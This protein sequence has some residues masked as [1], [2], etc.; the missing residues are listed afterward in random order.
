MATGGPGAEL[1][2]ARRSVATNR[3]RFVLVCRMSWHVR[4]GQ[5][6]PIQGIQGQGGAPP[7]CLT[8]GPG[9]RELKPL[10]EEKFDV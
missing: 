2:C 10:F 6:G 9:S 7:C 3:D 5:R 4:G 8:P 1:T